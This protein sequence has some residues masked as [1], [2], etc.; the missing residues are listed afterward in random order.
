MLC[1]KPEERSQWQAWAADT[2]REDDLVI[3]N[4]E[5]DWR[6][7]FMEWEASR[8]NKGGSFTINIVALLDEIAGAI[9]GVGKGEG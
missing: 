6:F 3:I 8:K 9:S 7:N 4:A 1:A 2:G 5:G